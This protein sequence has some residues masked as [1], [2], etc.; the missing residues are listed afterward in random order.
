MLVPVAKNILKA[1]KLTERLDSRL[2]GA[3]LY[4]VRQA[5]QHR[6]MK[7][8]SQPELKHDDALSSIRSDL[9]ETLSAPCPPKGPLS[10][11]DELQ[12]SAPPPPKLALQEGSQCEPQLSATSSRPCYRCISYME[13]AGIRRVFWTNEDGYWEGGKVRDL[14]DALGLK[15]ASNGASEVTSAGIFI[16]KHEILLLRRQMGN[17]QGQKER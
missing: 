3:D 10:L 6:K 17:H 15:E 9:S 7:R 12:C 4:V 11:Y 13:R 2:N 1:R 5:W 8:N 16:T 14:A